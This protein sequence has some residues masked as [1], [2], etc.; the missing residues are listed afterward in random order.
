MEPQGGV[1]LATALQDRAGDLADGLAALAEPGDDR[2]FAHVGVSVA[3]GTHPRTRAALDALGARVR[4]AA[5]THEE[6]GRERRLA[7]GLARASGAATVV[8]GDVDHVLRWLRAAP[9]EV[10]HALGRAADEG[11]DCLVVGR[12]AAAFAGFPAALGRTE[13]LVNEAYQRLT[14]H[15]WDLLSSVRVLSGR[16]ADLIVERSTVD[17]VATDVDWP[18]LCATA[19][20]RVGY[21][22]AAHL[23]Y[24]EGNALDDPGGPTGDGP[25]PGDARAWVLRLRACGWMSDAMA[26]YLPPLPP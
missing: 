20:L 5:R 8:A 17:T 14:G 9:G 1:G 24:V 25:D 18:L 23:T 26:A 4:V 6:V 16:A 21:E 22:E 10:H 2:P 12:P 3:D 15:A 7:L 19:G 11:L 13:P